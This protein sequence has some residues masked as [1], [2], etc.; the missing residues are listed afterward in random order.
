M[1]DAPL[2]KLMDPGRS[3]LRAP[4]PLFLLSL[5]SL[6]PAINAINTLLQQ[7]PLAN[8]TRKIHY[9]GQRRDTGRGGRGTGRIK[10]SRITGERERRFCSFTLWGINEIEGSGL[11]W[12]IEMVP[13]AK[14]EC[15][16]VLLTIKC[17]FAKGSLARTTALL[18]HHLFWSAP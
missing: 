13:F 11:A 5:C 12:K 2:I 15:S 10:G 8:V 7:I 17:V 9:E 16:L 4:G 3:L 14:R 18:L 6:L 1:C